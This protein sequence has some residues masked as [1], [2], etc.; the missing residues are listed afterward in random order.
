METIF[1]WLKS[2]LLN[3][4]NV[5]NY[6]DVQFFSKKSVPFSQG[7]QYFLAVNRCLSEEA[8]DR[9]VKALQSKVA[10]LNWRSGREHGLSP[11]HF[12]L[13][14]YNYEILKVPILNG[15]DIYVKKKNSG[16]NAL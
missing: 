6:N 14:W 16:Q 5:T 2:V 12:T 15:A 13:Y 10:D 7:C 11:M 1:C 4:N 9:I 8:A 3:T